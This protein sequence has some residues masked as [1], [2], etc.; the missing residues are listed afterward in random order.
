[1]GWRNND[2]LWPALSLSEKELEHV[3]YYREGDKPGVKLRVYGVDL[4]WV[5]GVPGQQTTLTGIY[6]PSGRYTRVFAMAVSGALPFWRLELRTNPGEVVIPST[7]VAALF[8]LNASGAAFAGSPTAFGLP[9]FDLLQAAP[10]GPLKFEPNLIL[11]GQT[12]LIC[13]GEILPEFTAG[14]QEG[15]VARAVL[16]IAFFVWEFP[17]TLA[18]L[19]SPKRD[20]FDVA[21]TVARGRKE[22]R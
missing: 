3:G 14:L 4:Q 18:H 15:D 19:R 2:V 7:G 6:K 20:N 11:P 9:N 8:S 21:R 12:N 1:M 17:D 16:H 5:Q 10:D 13:T 22:G